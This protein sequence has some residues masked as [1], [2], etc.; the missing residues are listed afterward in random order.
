MPKPLALA[1]TAGESF[2]PN[3]V[4]QRLNH[5]QYSPATL[6]KAVSTAVAARSFQDAAKLLQI[7]TDLIIS[8]RHLQNLAREVGDE[9]I[10]EQ[11][12]KTE[13]FRARRLNTPHKQ[14]EPPIP[15]AVVM[16][17][18]GRIQTRKPGSGPGVHDAAWR[19]T[20]TAILL[21]MTH[22]PSA[23]DPRP[24]LPE[25]FRHP[26]GTPATTTDCPPSDAPEHVPK[27]LFRTG[28]A[29][30]KDSDDFGF[31]VAGQAE[32][33]GF[34]S[35]K[36]GAFVGDGL[37]YNWTIHRRHFSS[38][39]PILDFVHAS[40]H[41]H[42][43]ARAIHQSGERWTTLCWQGRTSEVIQ[44][45]A[46]E[47]DLLTPPADPKTDPDHPWCVLD[48]EHGYMDNNRERMNYPEYRRDGLPITSSPMES[49]VKMVNQRV[50]GSEKFWNNDGHAEAILHLRSAWLGDEDVLANHLASR[51]GHPYAR[52]KTR[53]VA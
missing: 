10:Q 37:A 16:I 15:L 44:E 34:H 28:L 50:K 11:S 7:N 18:G 20:K 36:H 26:L 8:P 14:A 45:I 17:D 48:R 31:Q 33:R 49:W 52:P 40:E 51:P 32:D 42:A 29:S 22:E 38:F 4:R 25:C 3:R 2:S 27:T 21:R 41:L 35:A 19:E 23:L 24:D 5:R 30:L 47:R 39:T 1:R 13:A 9:L 43:A 53:M 12:K 46:A 6:T